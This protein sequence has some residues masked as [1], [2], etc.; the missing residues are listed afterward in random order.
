MT[1]QSGFNRGSDPLDELVSQLLACGGV[2]SQI[3]SQMI[4][5]EASGR[6]ASDAAPIPEVAHSVIRSVVDALPKRHSRR[7]IMVAAKIIDEVT[8]A[9]CEDIFIVHPDLN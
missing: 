9:I 7:D 1:Q 3:V 8:N 2:L 5:F 6:S 4:Q